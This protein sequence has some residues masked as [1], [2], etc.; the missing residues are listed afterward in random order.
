MFKM[1]QEMTRLQEIEFNV[2][3]TRCKDQSLSSSHVTYC[4][5]VAS[6]TVDRS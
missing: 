1:I 6:K 4:L 5:S 2:L 3:Q